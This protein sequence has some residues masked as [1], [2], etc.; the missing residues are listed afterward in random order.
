MIWKLYSNLILEYGAWIAAIVGLLVGGAFVSYQRRGFRRRQ[1]RLQERERLC[2]DEWFDA[3][4]P[5][6]HDRDLTC[7]VLARL[8]DELKI[9]WT[10]LRPD[11]TFENELRIHPRYSPYYDLEDT[12]DY[13][14]A[15]M[16][17]YDVPS[18]EWPPMTGDLKRFLSRVSLVC[19]RSSA[20]ERSMGS[21]GS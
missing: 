7:G 18:D 13:L 2:E 21:E 4:W 14:I 6:V 17:Q 11:D 3:F 20:A 10:Q 16:R 15:L 1:R 8:A 5:D 9:E 12:G 19:G